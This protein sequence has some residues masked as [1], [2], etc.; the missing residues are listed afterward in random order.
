MAEHDG[1]ARRT[2]EDCQFK[3]GRS[4]N[5]KGRPRGSKNAATIVTRELS[6]K[7]TVTENGRQR[8]ITKWEMIV[9]Q[10]VNKAAKGDLK[11]AEWV[12]RH[13]ERYGLLDAAE[14]SRDVG[15]RDE[16]ILNV[17]AA[18]LEDDTI[19][20]DTIKDDTW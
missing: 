3:S 9:I 16:E 18:I 17:Y 6:E 20:D 2:R 10:Q 1:K 14:A 13:A 19:K 4:G 12:A 5:P 15:A 7:V 11:A 8:K